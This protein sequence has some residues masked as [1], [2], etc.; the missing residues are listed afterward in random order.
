MKQNRL[1]RI[2]EQLRRGIGLTLFRVLQAEPVDLSGL[3][4]THVVTTSDLRGARVLVSV[5]NPAERRSTLARLQHHR[6]QIQEEVGKLVVLKYTPRLHF[7]LDTSLEEGD[8]VL[9]LLSGMETEHGQQ[10]ATDDDAPA[11]GGET[12]E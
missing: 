11:P 4:V 12:P 7:V 10:P 1:T 2:N 5:R 9:S 6:A 8:R 3:T